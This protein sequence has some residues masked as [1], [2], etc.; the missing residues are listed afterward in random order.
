MMD[1]MER[2]ETVELH[3]GPLDGYSTVV[4]TADP[5]PGTALTSPHGQYAGGRSW[6]QP[7]TDGVWWWTHDSP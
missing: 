5:D 2:W 7:D 4:D 3:G 1:V 6:Y